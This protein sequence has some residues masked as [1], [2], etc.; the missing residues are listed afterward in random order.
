MPM[1]PVSGSWGHLWVLWRQGCVAVKLVRAAAKQG[2]KGAE[3]EASEDYFR[4]S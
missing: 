2:R 3:L 4:H 1:M